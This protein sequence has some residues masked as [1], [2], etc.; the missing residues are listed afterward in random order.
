MRTIANE[1]YEVALKHISENR[2][3]IDRIVE[4]LMEKET[5]TGDEFR[6]MLAQ[7]TEIPAENLAAVEAQKRPAMAAAFEKVE[8]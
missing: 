2:E 5:L 6:A 8:L 4:A 7:Y 1:A 3:A